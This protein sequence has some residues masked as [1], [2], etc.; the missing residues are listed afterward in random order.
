MPILSFGTPLSPSPRANDAQR[1]NASAAGTPRKTPAAGSKSTA[2]AG[3]SGSSSSSA[4]EAGKTVNGSAA[5]RR[6]STD[7]S[8]RDENA[9]GA[10]TRQTSSSSSG[11][12]RREQ[13]Q[14]KDEGDA[15]EG[16][17]GERSM[18]MVNGN[19]VHEQD[20]ADDEQDDDLFGSH[21]WSISRTPRMRR[22]T[23]TAGAESM[24]GASSSAY[25][26]SSQRS[27]GRQAGE[28][29]S[30]ML[31]DELLADEE[32]LPPLHIEVRLRASSTIRYDVVRR[33]VYTHL[34]NEY[35]ALV[36]EQ[37]IHSWRDVAILC[38][39]VER[40]WVA[41]CADTGAAANDEVQ[42]VTKQAKVVSLERVTVL[43]HI[44]Q[45]HNSR[46]A[47]IASALSGEDEGFDDD[48]DEDA[49]DGSSLAG[50]SAASVLSLPSRSLEGVWD[51][52][53]Y[54]HGIKHGLL[55]Y[56]YSTVHFSEQNVDF[57]VVC[58]NRVVLLH[59]PPGTGKTSLCRALAQKL[60]VRLSD[61]CV[62]LPSQLWTT[63][64]K[65]ECADTQLRGWQDCRDQLALALL[66]VVLRVGQARPEAFR[67]HHSDRRR[68]IDV[69]RRP[70]RCVWPPPLLGARADSAAQTR[71]RA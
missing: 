10:S 41:E 23:E 24:N 50:S 13:Q 22:P 67:V 60:A 70:H 69:R 61:R 8:M 31:E 18:E 43:L 2:A 12:A 65:M 59:G 30:E 27:R 68:R 7:V 16:D 62:S 20:D 14:R 44:Y 25:L 53:I 29:A 51:T 42:G 6:Q 19:G 9:F 49:Q 46:D 36:T 21:D 1:T 37:E 56:V 35:A 58:W 15:N 3:G 5:S 57:N 11:A 17:E 45:T 54:E 34:A 33:I 4:R 66:Q 52:L 55:E 28:G 38:D 71:S 64:L 40:I 48:D 63:P 47:P 39:H 26:R 32:S